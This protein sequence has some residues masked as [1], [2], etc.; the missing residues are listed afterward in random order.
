MD[1][2]LTDDQ[3][4]LR[5]LTREI[6]RDAATHE[7]L[8]ELE[9]ESSSVFDRPLWQKL[10]TAG[11]TG[12]AVPEE[13][14]GGGLGF[15]EISLVCEEV[16]RTVAPIPVVPTLVTAY[17][18]GSHKAASDML[19]GVADG[20]T[21]LT[22]AFEGEVLASRDGD[23]YVL[24]GE[25]PFVPYG[26]EADVVAVP[27]SFGEGPVV[28]LV[29]RGARGLSVTELQTTNREPQAVLAFDG[30][31][32]PASDV[33]TGAADLV[34]DLRLHTTAALCSVAAGVCQAALD[35]TAKHTS[36]R[37][38]FGKPIAS[39]QAVGQR[40]ADAYIDTE[41]VRLTATQAVWRL[42]A[43]WP[44]DE[45]VAVAKFWVGD[46]GMRALHAC[47]HLHGGLGVDLDYPLHRYFVWG[48]QLEHELGTPIRQLLNLGAQLAA[49]PV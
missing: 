45:E 48:K 22:A 8:Q 37:E 32:V 42:S 10:A 30:V 41:M 6:L 33:A 23:D 7:H 14:G 36:S 43:G 15:V 39:F 2:S 5:D 35:M 44:A 47:Q 40:A 1:F 3:K 31:R 46:G 28:A 34:R 16:G 9:R 25:T 19:G 29:R 20:S 4:S 21:I 26:A 12:I 49:T 17:V 18:L 13:H 27:A 11:V 24:T 38:Q